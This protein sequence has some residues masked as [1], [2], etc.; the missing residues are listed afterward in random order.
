MNAPYWVRDPDG[1]LYQVIMREDISEIKWYFREHPDKINE[2]IKSIGGSSILPISVKMGLPPDLIQF[3]ID[4]G[5]RVNN[6]DL[7]TSLMNNVDESSDFETARI[8]INN[9]ADINYRLL[10]AVIKGYVAGK[11]GLYPPDQVGMKMKI[12]DFLF[13]IHDSEGR[14]VELGCHYKDKDGLTM[15][16]LAEEKHGADFEAFLRKKCNEQ[17][18]TNINSVL[19]AWEENQTS[20]IGRIPLDIIGRVA[21]YLGGPTEQHPNGRIRHVHPYLMS[22]I[23]RGATI[24]KGHEGPLIKLREWEARI[25]SKVRAPAS[26]GKKVGGRRRRTRRRR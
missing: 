13:G 22:S 3:L 15:F 25:K 10:N 1:Y 5:A 8:L 11:D 7:I 12:L 26:Q 2:E 17:A 23:L 4:K 19:A 24:P 20:G 21:E 14:R 16:K 9:G 6:R 18:A